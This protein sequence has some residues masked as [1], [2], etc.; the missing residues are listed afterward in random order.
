[1]SHLLGNC[2]SVA[3]TLKALPS[4]YNLDHQ[5]ITP[6]LWDSIR[7]LHS[8]LKILSQLYPKIQIANDAVNKSYFT[9][10]TSTELANVLTRKYKIPFRRAHKIVGLL[11]KYLI[12]NKFT[13]QNLTKKLLMKFL[14]GQT[15]LPNEINFQDIKDALDPKQ[16][17]E[18]H[19]IRGGP[20]PKE[21]M[22][23]VKTRKND[24][25]I[26]K[27]WLDKTRNELSI[28]HEKFEKLKKDLTTKD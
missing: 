14:E 25:N 15:I 26:S 24:L 4:S 3:S 5:E 28:A 12:E 13:C 21:V 9:F 17:I 2:V 18:K 8:S 6:Q 11:M 10:T 20:A 16:F 22:R 27:K 1:M 7:I 23:M 19:N